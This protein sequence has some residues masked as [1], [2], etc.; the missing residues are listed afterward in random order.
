MQQIKLLGASLLHTRYGHWVHPKSNRAFVNRVHD[1]LRNYPGLAEELFAIRERALRNLH[2]LE[3]EKRIQWLSQAFFRAVSIYGDN[4]S[5]CSVDAEEIIE[6]I[7][8]W[9]QNHSDHI[10]DGLFIPIALAN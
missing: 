5:V 9:F 8:E 4:V 6:D 2:T 7:D 10:A 3:D 1:N